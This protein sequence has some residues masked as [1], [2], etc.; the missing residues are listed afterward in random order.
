VQF[1]ANTPSASFDAEVAKEAV[2]DLSVAIVIRDI[3]T[4][5]YRNEGVIATD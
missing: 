2:P 5:E 4:A 3:R 1:R